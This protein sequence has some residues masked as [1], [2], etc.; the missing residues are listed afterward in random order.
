MRR[1][2]F[3]RRRIV[4]IADCTTIGRITFEG[5]VCGYAVHP[6]DDRTQDAVT[7]KKCKAI[8]KKARVKK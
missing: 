1:V 4:H 3:Y 2:R 8:A 5:T 6:Y 7:C